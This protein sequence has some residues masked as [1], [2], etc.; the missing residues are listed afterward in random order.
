MSELPRPSTA[1]GEATRRRLL[2]AAES[3]F[4]ERG[5]HAASVSSITRRAGV[6]QG[7][8]YLYFPG[9]EAALRELV[10]R[11]GRDLRRHLSAAS[12]GLRHRLDI[13][14][15]GLGAFVRFALEHSNLYRVVM[16]S[17]FVDETIYRRYYQDLADAYAEQ[18]SRAQQAGQVAPG[19]PATLA[20]AL[21]GLAHFLGLRYAIWEGSEPPES[22]MT[23]AI[24]F[25]RRALAAP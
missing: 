11:M 25:L 18:L 19:D 12:S 20:W 21:M 17:Q 2:D 24:A 9:K 3:E 1:R 8:F 6:A 15:A 13:E 10:E 23:T 4:G 5:Y 14:E 16:E 22:V 7:T